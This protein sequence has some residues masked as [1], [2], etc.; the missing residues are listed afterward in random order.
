MNKKQLAIALSKL[1]GFENPKAKLEQYATDSE[2]AAVFLWSAFMQGDIEGKKIADFAAG[3]GILGVGALLL[4]AKKV[5][6]VDLDEDALAIARE[7]L[8]GLKLEKNA[9]FFC[10]DAVDFHEKVDVVIQNPPFGVQMKNADTKCLEAA[11]SV[12]KIVYSMHKTSTS[13]YIHSLAEKHGF[14]AQEFSQMKFPLKKTMGHHTKEKEFID[15][16]LWV[17]RK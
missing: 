14:E 3:P 13:K 12:A 6:F 2:I 5:Y 11:F 1:K 15:A 16:S 7:N 9:A 4:N 10:G 8:K 17:F